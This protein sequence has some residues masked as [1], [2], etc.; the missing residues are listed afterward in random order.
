MA[1]HSAESGSN[2]Q[3]DDQASSGVSGDATDAGS[4]SGDPETP[5]SGEDSV[6]EEMEI[7][8]KHAD[9]SRGDKVVDGGDRVST[10][11]GGNPQE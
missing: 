11:E 7:A 10:D 8:R 5:D 1:D 2:T 9:P 6:E 3:P 4:S